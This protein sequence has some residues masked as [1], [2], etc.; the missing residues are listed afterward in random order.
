MS[1]KKYV[2]KIIEISV[3]TTMLL[4]PTIFYTLTNDVFEINKMFVFRF[5]TILSCFMG[6]I[7]FIIE[8]KIVI[9]KSDFDFPVLGY[10]FVSVL[11]TF[12]TKNLLTSIYGVYEDFEGILT[13]LNYIAIYYVVVNFIT[14]RNSINK[15]LI[16]IIIASFI[17]S[18]YGLAQNFGWD[19]VKWN[20]ETYSPDR[21]FSTLGNPNFLAA[22]LVEAIPILFILFFITHRTPQILVTPF[23]LLGFFV[24]SIL[25]YFKFSFIYSVLFFVLGISIILYLKNINSSFSLHLSH[26]TMKLFV[27]LILVASIMVLFMTKSRAGFFSFLITVMIIILYTIIDAQKSENELFS[28]NKKWFIAFALLLILSLFLPQ[29]QFAFRFL[30]ERSKTLLTFHGIVMTPRIYIWK[31]ALM[32]FRDFPIFGTGLDTFQVMF[33]YYRL[34]IYWQ[35]EWNGT[36][37]KTHNIFLQVLATQGIAGFSFYILLF[38]A[39]FK[40]SFKLIF[41]EKN[42]IQRYLVFSIFMAVIAYIIQGLFNYTV[43]AYGLFFWAALGLIISLDSTQKRFFVYNFSTS[44]TDFINKNKNMVIAAIMILCVIMEVYVARFW[45]A[46]I[47]FKIGNIGV[48]A[49]QNELAI[50]Y[51]LKSVILNPY[52]EIYWVKFGIAYEKAM[53]EQQDPN[54]RLAYI[55][56]AIKIHSHTIELNDMNGYNY[57]NL[58][59]VYKFYGEVADGSKYA[60]AINLYNKAIEKDPNNA[61]F[62]LDL[63]TIYINLRQWDKAI[64]ICKRYTELYPNFATPFSYLGYIYMLQ[65]TD[66]INEAKYYY[67][68]AIDNKQWFRDVVSQASTY[69]NLAIIYVNMKQYDK[70][71]E[72]FNK[73]VELRPDYK[74]GYLNLGRLYTMMNNVDKAIEM[75]ERVLRI[76][77]QDNRAITLLEQIKKIKGK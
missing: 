23:I 48:A 61:Y 52:R 5:F 14:K 63:T 30:W 36:P 40:K 28:K 16:A 37:E 46:D 50:P 62:G 69:S 22:Y 34:P 21:F 18:I 77:A 74:E 58:A 8:K 49:N 26:L 4:V 39:F 53:R 6:L 10:L 12:I 11:T 55:N 41:Y 1:I 7:I 73:A 47:Y 65:G 20:P 25:I 9:L 76:D 35:L 59:R 66:K 51:Y 45:A 33:P 17:I 43:V 32:M 54:K 3:I 44:F 71:I 72:M 56:E 24:I 31:S 64:E 19:F 57:N 75:Y 38:I 27:L 29:I 68:Q 70:A 2:E 13:I 60:E 15:I 42:M 67:E